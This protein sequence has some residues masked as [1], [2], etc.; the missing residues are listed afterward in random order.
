[1]K[2]KIPKLLDDA[3]KQN[4]YDID[5]ITKNLKIPWLKLDMEFDKPTD[6][7]LLNLYSKNSWREKWQY[8]TTAFHAYQVKD[9][10]GDILFGPT[11]WDYFMKLSRKEFELHNSDEDSRCKKLRNR[12][13][14]D[15]FVDDENYVKK[16]VKKYIPNDSDINLV[17]SYSLP[18]NGYVFPHRDYALDDMGLAKIYIALR[19]PKNNV[20][21]MYGCGNI[22]IK[23]GDVFLI[24]NYTLPHWVCNQSDEERIVL[25]ISANLHSPIIKDKIIE[26][27][28]KT[29]G[30]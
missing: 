17:N 30:S 10:S 7:E 20:F 24:N 25:D 19:W 11:D 16:Q 26:A 15:W 12:M 21:G 4:D 6:S 2:D 13:K 8:L 23:E 5:V 18:A 28:K 27:F 1:M 29:F 9:W 14:Y 3:I 22:P